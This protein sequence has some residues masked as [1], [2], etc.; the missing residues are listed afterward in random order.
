MDEEIIELFRQ[1]LENPELSDTENFFVSGGDSMKAGRIISTLA[2]KYEA[3]LT[4]M[5]IFTK[6]TIREIIDSIQFQSRSLD[7]A[8]ITTKIGD[9]IPLAIQ[10]KEV[11]VHDMI[12]ESNVFKIIASVE[13]FGAIKIEI[14]KRA[15]ADIV[16][17]YPLF[18]T[19]ILTEMD[20]NYC[21]LTDHVNFLWET[22]KAKESEI[23][24]LFNKRIGITKEQEKLAFYY[25]TT[26][27]KRGRLYIGLHHLWGD[28]TTIKILLDR[29]WERYDACQWLWIEKL[30]MLPFGY[31]NFVTM[32]QEIMEKTYLEFW[33][34]KI[35]NVHY[36]A[37][38]KKRSHRKLHDNLQEAEY[39]ALFL[40]EW[41]CERLK[42]KAQ[43]CACSL[44]SIFLSLFKLLIYKITNS[45]NVLIGFPVRSG[46]K[47]GASD[48]PGLYVSQSISV[49]PVKESETIG[50]FVSEIQNEISENI[51]YSILPFG[52]ICEKLE[53]PREFRESPS[54]IH[55][56][57]IEEEYERKTADGVLVN[58]LTFFKQQQNRDFEL[59]I[60]KQ[61]RKF[62]IGFA[63]KKGLFERTYVEN[64]KVVYED[65]LKR[66]LETSIKETIGNLVGKEEEFEGE[67]LDL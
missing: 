17:S 36:I 8:P 37:T 27:E 63:Y 12:Y 67:K 14:L 54:R 42:K 38:L 29:I 6:S 28:E 24:F 1:I 62:R 11:L 57:Y 9:K 59:I 10:Q 52:Y 45:E 56:N 51:E 61:G 4:Y 22:G 58:Q 53:L 41:S 64:I 33:R 13:V 31:Q 50:K 15:V 40:D 60:G 34:K 55:F 44:Y 49:I 25:C 20:H 32:Q 39:V 7:E 46:A 21:I 30:P 3:E 26:G 16:Q 35:L 43:E 48:E 66:F 2:E 19:E 5:D 65:L 23:K 18:R 47:R